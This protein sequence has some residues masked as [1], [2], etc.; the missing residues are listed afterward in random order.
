M[1]EFFSFRTM[2]TPTIIK[3]IFALWCIAC[4]VIGV[5]IMITGASGQGPEAA[6]GLFGGLMVILL[7][8]LV[9]R[10]YC[11]IVIVI[12]MINEHLNTIRARLEQ[13]GPQ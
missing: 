6:A 12:F 3:I 4:V 10:I 13:P 2:I 7:G 9:G 8:P 5:V 11:E 1:N